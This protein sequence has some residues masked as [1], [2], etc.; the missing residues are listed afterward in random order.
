[1]SFSGRL[2]AA[3]VLFLMLEKC[4]LIFENANNYLKY[5]N[6]YIYLFRTFSILRLAA[7]CPGAEWGHIMLEPQGLGVVTQLWYE[8]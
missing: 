1:M 8:S 2:Q 6:F 3:V 4:V 5:Y 7:L